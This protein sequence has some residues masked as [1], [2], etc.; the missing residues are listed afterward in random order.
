MKTLSIVFSSLLFTLSL[1]YGCGSGE[2]ATTTEAESSAS[3]SSVVNTQY[4]SCFFSEEDYDYCIDSYPVEKCTATQLEL[5]DS[6]TLQ[7]FSESC[8]ELGF[9]EISEF[10]IDDDGIFY[11]AYFKDTQTSSSVSSE[12][13]SSSLSNSSEISSEQESS[14]SSSASSLAQGVLKE[15]SITENGGR[16]DTDEII[17][18]FPVAAVNSAQNI[19]VRKSSNNSYEILGIPKELLKPVTITFPLDSIGTFD[20]NSTYIAYEIENSCYSRSL[21]SY[22]NCFSYLA[23]TIEGD[24]LKATIPANSSPSQAP[25]K[26]TLREQYLRLENNTTRS[27]S[28]QTTIKKVS[29]QN[30]AFNV[31][32]NQKDFPELNENNITNIAYQAGLGIVVADTK[33]SLMGFDTDRLVRPIPIHIRSAQDDPSLND[34]V[35]Y[36]EGSTTSQF[37]TTLCVDKKYYQDMIEFYT[38]I[39]H[40]YF[41][42]VQN[43]YIKDF[44][45]YQN[46]WSDNSDK[47]WLMEASSTW[48]EYEMVDHP[49]SYQPYNTNTYNDF[50]IYGL[51]ADFANK[52]SYF[53][54]NNSK[55]SIRYEIGYGM[56]LF[57]RYLSAIE[58]SS[59]IYDIW[60]YDIW[61]GVGSGNMAFKA[62][63][64]ALGTD[65]LKEKWEN[66]ILLYFAG[67]LPEFYPSHA[68]WQTKPPISYLFDAGER[69]PL[70]EDK[71]NFSMASFSALNIDLNNTSDK[72]V[73]Y[74]MRVSAD[75]PLSVLEIKTDSETTT[76]SVN[77]VLE[78]N[79]T[80]AAKKMS[81][82]GFVNVND[83]VAVELKLDPYPEAP[84]INYKYS[85][86]QICSIWSNP[87]EGEDRYQEISFTQE[88]NYDIYYISAPI[89]DCESCIL[90]TPTEKDT[91]Y[92]GNSF[93]LDRDSRVYAVTISPEGLKSN[94]A[95]TGYFYYGGLMCSF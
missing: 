56:G 85:S 12:I 11:N 76:L 40:E 4:A 48:F 52:N 66:F 19:T 34:A 58:G 13:T 15:Q 57:F 18:D 90:P 23:T 88:K 64:G 69:E 6:S 63:E 82:I 49:E 16:I 73:N 93:I 21:N 75:S 7:Q 24:K 87:E 67:K 59:I 14:E 65:K 31:Y 20:I 92:D 46:S 47:A 8:L 54:P 43:A 28:I 80:I 91:H 9:W 86:D 77:K 51:Y 25:K 22:T 39:G 42:A 71:S 72:E 41:H 83:V 74:R 61:S 78:H 79:I 53:L 5:T 10:E 37:E 35:G 17:L 89:T 60:S 94:L 62:I 81:K 30:N 32:I 26:R 44:Q 68:L 3:V 95:I 50:F 2:S 33:L 27:V 70:A 45:A 36:A 55:V 84:I 38:T 1:F 29:M